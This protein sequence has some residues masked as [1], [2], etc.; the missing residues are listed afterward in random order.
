MKERQFDQVSEIVRQAAEE[1]FTREDAEGRRE[2]E[3]MAPKFAMEEAAR[4]AVG[5]AIAEGLVSREQPVFEDV[6]ASEHDNATVAEGSL[7][8]SVARVVP[9][10]R[11]EASQQ[12]M[13]VRLINNGEQVAQ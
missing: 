10:S 5:R 11:G 3:L 7:V 4:L 9:I 12:P 2:F 13:D 8:T 1:V 6:T